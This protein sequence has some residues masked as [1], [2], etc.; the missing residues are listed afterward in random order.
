[1]NKPATGR[2]KCWSGRKNCDKEAVFASQINSINFLLFHIKTYS[3]LKE[4]CLISPCFVK[5]SD[6]RKDEQ[7]SIER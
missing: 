5:E 2:K 3:L 6:W 4:Y 7:I 1:M